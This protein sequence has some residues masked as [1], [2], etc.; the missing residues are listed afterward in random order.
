M[1]LWKL[2][3]NF[4]FHPLRRYPGPRSSAISRVPHAYACASGQGHNRILQLHEK[5]GDC[6]RVALNELSICSPEVW[7]EVFLDIV[8]TLLVRCPDVVFITRR[9]RT[10]FLVHP[11]KSTLSS[12]EFLQVVSPIKPCQIKSRSCSDLLIYCEH[13][14]RDDSLDVEH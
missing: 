8:R 10:A 12:V 11:K 14:T 1:L 9:Q 6:I 5:Y 13:L 3:Y 7:K 4:A 2:I